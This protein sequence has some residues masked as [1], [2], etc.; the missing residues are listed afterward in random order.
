MTDAN[1]ILVSRIKQGDYQSF[2]RLFF[3]YYRS[4]CSYVSSIIDDSSAAEDIV[5]NLFVKFWTDRKKITIHKNIESYL[6]K[7]AKHGAF[8]YLRSETNRKNAMEKMSLMDFSDEEYSTQEEFLQKLE[9]CINQLPERSKEVF[10]LHRYEGLKQKEIAGK[11]NI[12]VKT[13]KN[14]VWKSLKYLKSCMD[15]KSV[16]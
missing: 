9:E 14:Q 8:N 10:L 12:S 11:L 13:I 4:L 15:I 3:Q 1:K 2:N 6:F 5:Q 7:A 16:S